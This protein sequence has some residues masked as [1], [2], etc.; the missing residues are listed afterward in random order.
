[1]R[2]SQRMMQSMMVRLLCSLGVGIAAGA[3]TMIASFCVDI[4]LHPHPND[5]SYGMYG[6]LYGL[7]LAPVM[8]IAAAVWMYLL[9]RRRTKRAE[10]AAALTHHEQ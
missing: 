10:A 2:Q 3:V 8:G 6:F 5:G 1:M 7:I 4:W 9:M